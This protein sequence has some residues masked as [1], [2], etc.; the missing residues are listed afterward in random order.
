[1]K[2]HPRKS[3]RFQFIQFSI[4]GASNALIDIGT[5]NLLLLLFHSN[6]STVLLLFN[7]ISYTLAILNSYIWNANITFK[8]TSEGSTYQRSAFIVQAIVSLVISNV[9]F[10]VAHSLF[11]I[12]E[13]PAWWNYNIAKVLAMALSSLASFFMVK[14]FVFKDY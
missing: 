11:M 12:M 9:V 6:Q 1:M 10:I 13:M 2:N 5:L 8:R 4:I 7:T 14:F 3:G